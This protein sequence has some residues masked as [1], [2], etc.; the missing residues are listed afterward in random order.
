MI[1]QWISLSPRH[2]LKIKFKKSVTDLGTWYLLSYYMRSAE[3]LSIF[4]NKSVTVYFER[5]VAL[6][7]PDAIIQVPCKTASY[8]LFAKRPSQEEGAWGE[9]GKSLPNLLFLWSH[10]YLSHVNHIF[11]SIIYSFLKLWNTII[12]SLCFIPESLN[13]FECQENQP[14]LPGEFLFLLWHGPTLPGDTNT[15]LF[16]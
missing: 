11:C 2:T 7:S 5:S 13:T 1:L 12:K 14:H 8:F 10:F 9:V 6:I 4:T 16:S 15:T 3:K